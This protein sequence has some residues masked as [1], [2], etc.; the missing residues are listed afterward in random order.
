MYT[1]EE[2]TRILKSLKK[3]KIVKG[4]LANSSKV[5]NNE[6]HFTWVP[7]QHNSCPIM[8]AQ[9]LPIWWVN[10]S[11]NEEINYYPQT[12]SSVF[13]PVLSDLCGFQF[14]NLP[15]GGTT[16]PPSST[17]LPVFLDF[18]F[19]RW[20]PKYRCSQAVILILFPKPMFSL[21]L[22]LATSNDL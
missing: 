4:Y 10:K 18:L 8:G 11:I 22:T 19:F 15:L 13:V 9:Y 2:A 20:P 6:E 17:S 5:G 14:Q 3:K 1:T 12:H 16:R 21:L 7:L